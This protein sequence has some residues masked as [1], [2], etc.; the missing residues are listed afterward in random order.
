MKNWYRITKDRGLED[1][2][3]IKEHC[4]VF[5][6]TDK[7]LAKRVENIFKGIMDEQP[8]RVTDCPWK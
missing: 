2:S 8:D 4:L 1:G 5:E 7:T 3:R 6:T